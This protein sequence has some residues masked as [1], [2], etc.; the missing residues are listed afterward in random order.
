MV[1][2]TNIYIRKTMQTI[3]HNHRDKLM[4]LDERFFLLVTICDA[5]PYT[6]VN[7]RKEVEKRNDKYFKKLGVHAMQKENRYFI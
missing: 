5:L 4:Q 7:N 2:F 3:A 1:I 6:I